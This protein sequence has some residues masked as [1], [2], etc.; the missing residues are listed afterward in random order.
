M[1][2]LSGL[3]IEEAVTEQIFKPD[4]SALSIAEWVWTKQ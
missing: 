1:K 3:N 4:R 2:D